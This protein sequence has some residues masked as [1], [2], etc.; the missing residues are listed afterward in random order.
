M[1]VNFCFNL[2]F[3]SVLMRRKLDPNKLK[4]LQ[5]IHISLMAG[6]VVF[7]GFV[8]YTSDGFSFDFDMN[9]SFNW[10]AVFIAFVGFFMGNTLFNKAMSSVDRTS[11]IDEFFNSFQTAHIVRMAFLE[12]PALFA[13][14]PKVKLA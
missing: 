8:L 9:E 2:V 12:G 1:C 4:A 5:L 6:V 11:S 13:V 10:V 14:V 3:K 7:T